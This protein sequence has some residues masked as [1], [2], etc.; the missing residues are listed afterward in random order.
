MRALILAL[1]SS[2]A[3]LG[4]FVYL[5]TDAFPPG[6]VRLVPIAW[7]AGTVAAAILAAGAVRAGHQRWPAGLAL[8]LSIPSAAL[9]VVFSLAALMGD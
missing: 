6:I 3:G 5:R 7:L 4:Y 9:A 1:A 2:A 8:A